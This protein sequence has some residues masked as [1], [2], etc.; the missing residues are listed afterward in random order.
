VNRL[1]GKVGI[2]TGA[3]SGMGQ[4]TALAFAREGASVVVADINEPGSRAVADE[5][6][7]AGGKALAMHVDISSAGDMKMMVDATVS[8]FGR[9]DILDNNA[10]LFGPAARAIDNDIVNI[11]PADWDRIFAVNVRGPYLGC[12]YAVPAMIAS[13]GGAIINISST[14]AQAGNLTR[15][16]YG[17]TKAAINTLTFHVATTYGRQ[18][19]RCNAVAPGPVRTPAWNDMT[20]E[21]EELLKRHLLTPFIGGP[22]HIANAVVFLASDEAAYITGQVLCVDGGYMAHQ[23]TT[24]ELLDRPR[25]TP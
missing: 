19:I 22:E 14:S 9:L 1:E 5:I 23:P 18:G 16:A 12:K 21:D 2:V 6:E 13:G 4:A 24:G 15:H 10:S 7:A 20:A 25:T 3:A 11:D 17:S 8:E